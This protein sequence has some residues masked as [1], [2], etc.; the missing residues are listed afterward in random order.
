M[1]WRRKEP[2]HQQTWYWPSFPGIFRFQH[3]EYQYALISFLRTEM[4]HWCW[5]SFSSKA[6][7][8]PFDIVIT[9]AD[10]DLATWESGHQHPWYQFSWSWVNPCRMS[11]LKE[12]DFELTMHISRRVPRLEMIIKHVYCLTHSR[13][14]GRHFADDILKCIFMNEN[15]CNSTQISLKFVPNGPIDKSP[16]VRVMA[17]RRTCDKPLSEARLIPSSPTQICSTPGRLVNTSEW[18]EWLHCFG[19]LFYWYFLSG[20]IVCHVC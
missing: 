10:D 3:Q 18:L 15:F 14:N 5:T 6:M 11:N 9:A 7:K 16:L 13:Q 20:F 17:W 12:L 19:W 2:G 1:F 8:S 4:F